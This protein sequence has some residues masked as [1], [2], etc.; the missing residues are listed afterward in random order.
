[1][2]K[3][4]FFLIGVLT[5][6]SVLNMQAQDESLIMRFDFS[7][8]SGT[9]VTDDISGISAKLINNA[10]VKKMG[11]Y[12]VLDLGSSNG[13][14]NMTAAAGELISH[15]TNY[16]I[17]V[18]YYINESADITGAGNF[19]WA[20]STL[21]GCSAGGG[22]YTA[23]RVNLQRIA[24]STGG[25]TGE[26][27]YSVGTPSPK[28]AWMHVAYTQLGSN[29]KLYINGE[30][31]TTISGMPTNSSLFKDTKPAYCWIGRPHFSGDNYLKQTLVS[32]FRLYNRALS[33][34]EVK[35]FANQTADMDNAYLFGTTGD[36]T[37]L[38]NVIKSA[39]AIL[40]SPD[41][42][43]EDAIGELRGTTEYA[44][45]I[46]QG[47]Y[48]QSYMDNIKNQLSALITN[49]KATKGITLPTVTGLARAYDTER[50]FI[51]PGGLHT[52][53]DFDRIKQQ[54]AD[55]NEKVKAAYEVLRTAG[56]A[57]AG[58]TS[59]P[60][61]I[62][63][64][65][66]GVGENYMNAARAG[67]MAYQNALRWKIEDNKACAKTAVDILMA[68]AR[69]T[70]G[71]GGDT[72]SALASG[73][74]GY[75]FAQ[76]AEL[77]RDYE[78][79]S[80]EDFEEF[81]Q[82]MIRVWYKH[83]ISFLR[84]RHGTWENSGKWWQA[85][86]HYWSNWPLC[87]IMCVASIGILCDDVYMYNQAMSFF[88]YD[89]VGNYK[90][91]P[92]L[93]TVTGH[94]E[95]D[96]QQA[97]WNDGLTD[98]LGNLVVTDVESDLET[99]AYGRI[100]QMNE[101]GRD[102]GHS[103]MAA[104]LMID[105][106]KLGWNQGDDLFAYMD[107]RVASGIEFI[108][109]QTQSVENLPWTPYL[110]INNGYAYTD[111]RS[112]LMTEPAMGTH[113]RPY[114]GTVIG[115]YEGVKGVKMPF[116]ELAYEQMGIDG[117]GA[118]A[119]SGGYDHLGYSV[120][121][122]T[123]DVQLCPADNV[124]T[125]LSGKIEY[126][127]TINSNLIPSLNQ[128]KTRGLVNGKVISHNELGGLV[129][130]YKANL[131]TC[132]P[133][134]NTLTLMP[135]L[136]EGEEDTGNWTWNTGETTRDITVSSDRSF[137]YRVKYVNKNGVESQLCF[138]IAVASDCQHTELTPTIENEGNSYNTNTLTVMFG[139]TPTL[140]ITPSCDWGTFRW[141]T[142]QTTSSI[143][144]APVV[145]P[146]DYTVYYT[147]QAAAV[148]SETF[149]INVMYTRQYVT[150]SEGTV[151]TDKA[152][153]NA[154]DNVTCMLEVPAII[155]T[156]DIV[157]NDGTRGIK[158]QLNDVQTSGT[159]SAT[160]TINGETVTSTFKVYV[161]NSEQTL[162]EPGNYVIRHVDSGLLLTANGQGELVTFEEG[163]ADHP[164]AYQIWY[165]NNNGR[166]YSFTSMVDDLAI[167]S[168]M[169][170]STVSLSII[171]AD[172]AHGT[173]LYALSTGSTSSNTKYWIMNEDGSIDNTFTTITDYPYEFIKV[174]VTGIESVS[175]DTAYPTEYYS[176]EG[177]R[178]NSPQR[179][180]NIVRMS[181]GSTKTILIK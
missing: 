151:Q 5:L 41:G 85:P 114:W 47:N 19:V 122:N 71:V 115:I 132:V 6:M 166:R 171:N 119:T 31:V 48:S 90:E 75:E 111:S 155:N 127:G 86:G 158:L 144:T 16:S 69:V 40:N 110:Y 109:A 99:A 65:G 42:Y 45:I 104:G 76:A 14:L 54:L 92:E 21:E 52:Q 17:S 105:V 20:F 1:M 121:M 7:N 181:D 102:A 124:P 168:S 116:S 13:Y 50:G 176:L 134:G 140:I 107:H 72:N 150:T 103:A 51:H 163:D 15:T 180:L 174:D 173:D 97:I 149:H 3:K 139:Q 28:G 39:D 125:E 91:V 62:V 46:A 61:E 58:V 29:G 153:L 67:A 172:Q 59:S 74:Y 23:Y 108:G 118:G 117:G 83:A 138:P 154:G 79:W 131:N 100:G 98:F 2:K 167:N 66:G 120:L 157:W 36:P 84:T 64:R 81:K 87:N 63:V 135:Q 68:W 11:D 56:Y 152:V 164:S 9:T 141:S 8:V 26:K 96:G 137:I 4:S 148:S 60:T 161:K 179:G 146:R 106:A 35:A 12:D 177:I 142:G 37:A 18:Y 165:V 169:K 32:D 178:R 22:I 82:W 25:F 94:G 170:L 95:L 34:D 101:S 77:V 49:V 129:N 175:D 93:H 123:R 57:Q 30:L 147:N 10:K 24:A 113:V 160:F 43:L 126:S 33:E 156:N 136:P 143:T 70:K 80:A 128:E 73:L 27:G 88:K 44:R 55:G 159:Y 145:A 78:G 53:E 89:Q 130:T 133:K 162:L 112:W 38:N